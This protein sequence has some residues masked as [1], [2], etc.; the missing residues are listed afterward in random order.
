MSGYDEFQRIMAEINYRKRM[1]ESGKFSNLPPGF[2][3]LFG[4][5]KK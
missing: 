1:E 2:E 3:E 4:G 5:F